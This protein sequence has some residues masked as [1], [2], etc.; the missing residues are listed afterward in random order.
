MGPHITYSNGA[1]TCTKFINSNFIVCEKAVV[2]NRFF[3]E[4]DLPSTYFDKLAKEYA[5]QEALKKEHKE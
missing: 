4:T 2:K 5:L 3:E 1:Y